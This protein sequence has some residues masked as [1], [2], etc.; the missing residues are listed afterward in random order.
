MHG[1]SAGGRVDDSL[2]ET[3]AGTVILPADLPLVGGQPLTSLL[4]T[5]E[6]DTGPGGILGWWF[7]VNFTGTLATWT[8][9]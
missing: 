6:R 1:T 4:R 9:P 5:N 7:H 8:G 2:D 3:T